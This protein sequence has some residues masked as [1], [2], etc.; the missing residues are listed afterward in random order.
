MAERTQAMVQ[1]LASA[2]LARL[3][4]FKFLI[5]GAV[6]ILPVLPT[7]ALEAVRCSFDPSCT[8]VEWSWGS[9]SEIEIRCPGEGAGSGWARR[10]P[11]GGTPDIIDPGGSFRGN[12]RLAGEVPQSGEVTDGQKRKINRAKIRAIQALQSI[13]ECAGLF[14]NSPLPLDGVTV[15]NK[16]KWLDGQHIQPFN[17]CEE[18]DG[19]PAYY[20]S[21]GKHV[22]Q[23]YVCDAIEGFRDE[24]A[25]TLLIH[26]ALHVSGQGEDGSETA[27]PGNYPNALGI[28][29]VVAEACNLPV[30]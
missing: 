6:L 17:R 13:P 23:I 3:H 28:S 29:F 16:I 21:P 30:L 11:G 9:G 19:R 8:C 10:E 24:A 20:A 26:E 12:G 22:P 25:A 5:I 1:V 7:D 27:G 2:L 15:L 18:P 4:L 14:A